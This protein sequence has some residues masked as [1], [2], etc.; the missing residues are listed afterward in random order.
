MKELQ[1]A[2][3]ITSEREGRGVKLSLRRDMWEAYLRE[4]S[5]L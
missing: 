5:S 4:L 1:D 3:L 2:G